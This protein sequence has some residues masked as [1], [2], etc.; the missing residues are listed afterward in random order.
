MV[1]VSIGGP[2]FS[3][4]K[5]LPLNPEMETPTH[6]HC[7]SLC[8]IAVLLEGGGKDFSPSRRISLLVILFNPE[9]S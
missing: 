3:P 2:E 1:D 7:N 9:V 6:Y 4:S 5:S 8:A